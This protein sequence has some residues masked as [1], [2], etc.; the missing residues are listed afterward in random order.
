MRVQRPM[1]HVPGEVRLQELLDINPLF[2]IEAPAQPEDMN[3]IIS[4]ELFDTLKKGNERICVV[5]RADGYT[6]R[7]ISDITGLTQGQIK[8]II[9]TIRKRIITKTPTKEILKRSKEQK[10]RYS[11]NF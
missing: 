9:Y 7:S 11:H 10:D 2:D 8:N 4:T 3:E 6:Y 5:L 1:P